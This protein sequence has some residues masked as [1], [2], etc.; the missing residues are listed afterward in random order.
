MTMRSICKLGMTAAA[1]ALM[2]TAANAERYTISGKSAVRDQVMI[3]VGHRQDGAA[4]ST[5]NFTVTWASGKKTAGTAECMTWTAPPGSIFSTN[6]VCSATPD[7]G[8]VSLHSS[9]QKDTKTNTQD[10]WKVQ[11]VEAATVN[12]ATTAKIEFGGNPPW[13]QLGAPFAVPAAQALRRVPGT[14]L[15]DRSQSECR[16]RFEGGRFHA[17]A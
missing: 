17:R 16:G 9:C 4:Y 2:S 5:G 8:T 1:L 7:E 6:A 13:L 15:A 12:L 14:S 10:C 11:F 3:Q